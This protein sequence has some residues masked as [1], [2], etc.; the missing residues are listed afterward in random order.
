MNLVEWMGQEPQLNKWLAEQQAGDRTL[1][2]GLGPS[3]KA[4]ALTT[5][6]EQ[7]KA[8]VLV[9]EP[10]TLGVEQLIPD[11]QSLTSSATVYPFPVDEVLATEVA[12]ASPESLAARVAALTAL[13]NGEPGIFVVSVAALS[14]LLPSPEIWQQQAFTIKIDGEVD[15]QKLPDRLV[16]MGYRR[17]TLVSRPGEF[18][19]R[20][21]LID[22]FPLTADHPIRVE[23]FD[24]AVDSLRVFDEG[25]QRSM[26]NIDAVTIPPATDLIVP[27]PQLKKVAAALQKQLPQAQ[28]K[29]TE[30]VQDA[31]A[32]NLANTITDFAQGELGDKANLFRE[33]LFGGKFSLLNY[34]TAKGTVFLDDYA[35]INE[36]AASAE[37]DTAEWQTDLLARGEILPNAELQADWRGDLRR[38]PHTRVYLS[39]F[40]KG[41]AHVKLDHL[42]HVTSHDVP[43]FFSQMPM[44]KTEIDRYQK[45]NQTVVILIQS[46][47]RIEKLQQ[48]LQDFE[49]HTRVTSPDELVPGAVQLVHGNLSAGFSL[50][51]ANLVVLTEHELFN[52]V[53]Q[54]RPRPAHFSNAERIKSYNELKPGDYVVHVNHG[55]GKYMGIQTLTVDGKHQDYITIQYADDGKLFIPVTQ[56]KMVQK[57]VGSEGK[58]PHLNKLGGSEWQKTKRR[59]AKKIEDIADDLIAL[60]AERASQKGYAFSPDNDYQRE[61]EAA[62]AYPETPDQLRSTTEIKRD[63]EKPIPMDRLLVGDVGFGKTEVALR[64]AFKAIQDGKQVAFLVPTT[65]LAQQ[66]YDTMLDRFS[67]FPVSVGMLSRFVTAADA[68]KTLAGLKNGKVDIVVGTHRLLSND[69]QFKDLGLLIID[70]EQRFGVKHKE[71]IKSLKSNVDV[72]T[73]TATPIP[74]TL[75]MSMLGVRDL[76]V[77]ETPPANRYPIQTYVLEQ[78]AGTIKNAIEREMARNG[79]VFYMHNRVHDIE[80]TVAQLQ[81]L[82]PEATIAYAHGQMT[83]SQLERVI[84]DFVHGQYDVL[85]TTTIIET[86]VDMPN[87]NTLIVENADQYGLSQLYQLRGRI[88]RSSRI[89]YAYFMYQQNKVLTEVGEKRL[90]AIRDFTELGSG[91][92]IAMR[93]L[94][95]RGA[96]NLLGKQ[97]HG[98]IDSVG[99]DMYTQMLHDAVA[100]KKGQ[101]TQERT[102]AEIDLD[103]EAY[104]PPD[105]IGDP[106]QKIEIYKRIQHLTSTDEM[107]E[108]QS[109]LIDRFG[110]YDAPVARLLKVGLLKNQ[111]DA[112]LLTKIERKDAHW[113]MSI[114][115]AGRAKL[116]GEDL[117]ALLSNT[118]LQA[119]VTDRDGG[120][121]ITLIQRK[122]ITDDAMIDTF[123]TLTA[124]LPKIEKHT[125]HAGSDNE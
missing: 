60:Y 50:P 15:P 35:R 36:T 27:R 21:D 8:P 13:A 17:D 7:T 25:D 72:L 91:F 120:F 90:A 44:L 10:T 116:G 4:L 70:E 20:G 100:A 85:V 42:Y 89:A 58:T 49:I 101:K 46:Q 28:A 125:V 112:A 41:M 95:I 39:V 122:G 23:L 88:G 117:F 106:R 99:Y 63:M 22:I 24:T 30:S 52:R 75:N 57:Y 67:D 47:H 51:E 59:V 111:A 87:A 103:V 54:A 29:A 96:G 32:T 104:L 78:N 118:S 3:A 108:L 56:M 109:D 66:H 19:I 68:K 43:Q 97:Q 84:Y 82:V 1:V 93:D 71:K 107:E 73:L 18:A 114:G 33:Q 115:P 69:V 31:L 105:Y 113:T 48:T 16:T 64:A 86:G 61:F 92:K 83:E 77:I 110:E 123:M 121:Q 79:Q 74:R 5:Y 12:T 11:L 45:L 80:R 81:E 14:H 55:I 62:F 119:Q 34:L 6:F 2:I 65:I 40:Q 9:V 76:S 94:S 124:A 37:Q 102:D 98:F 53:R 26:D 38:D